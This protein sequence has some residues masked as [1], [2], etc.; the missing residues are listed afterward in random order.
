M[1]FRT[2]ASA[3]L[4]CTVLCGTL[5]S[6]AADELAEV[7]RLRQQGQVDAALTRADSFL[8]SHPK[9]A[10]MR[11][12]KAS[13]LADM[14][15]S[16]EAIAGFESLTQ[17]HPDLAEPYNNLAA[18]YAS[19]GDYSKARAALEQAVRLNPGY[20]TAHENLGDVYAALAA[21]SY[22]S[23][24]RLD[25]TLAGVQGKLAHVRQLTTPVRAAS[26]GAT[27]AAASQPAT[28]R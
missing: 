3:V 15:R 4:A 1:I 24:L 19:A 25:P 2:L 13:L 28:P 8:A 11:F 20:A 16:S 14:K 23:A 12:A 17:D 22:A 26:V 27:G 5:P 6:M 10:Q 18:L 21:Q 9:D 7:L